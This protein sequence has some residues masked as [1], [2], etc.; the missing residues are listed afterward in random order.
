MLV[1]AK[2][3]L[4]PQLPNR[5]PNGLFS[6]TDCIY[7]KNG[8]IKPWK[9]F[10]FKL[11]NGKSVTWNCN[12]FFDCDSK[13]VLYILIG[14][15][16]DYLS[17]GKTFDFKQRISKHKPDVK[18]P[19]NSTCRERAEHLRDCVKNRAFFQINL[20]YDEKD[21]FLETTKKNDLLL[22]GSYSYISIKHDCFITLYLMTI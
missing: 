22:N 21:N 6:C 4:H 3:D 17:L 16:C 12:K 11:T 19:Q 13:D 9:Q 1:T 15:N 7:H 20:F 2:F 14:N 5:K 8:Y 10:T 18:H